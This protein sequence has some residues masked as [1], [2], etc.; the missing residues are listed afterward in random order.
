MSVSHHRKAEI[1]AKEKTTKGEMLMTEDKLIDRK[2]NRIVYLRNVIANQ[3]TQMD[4]YRGE[5]I[6]IQALL[7]EDLVLWEELSV[8]I[9]SLKLSELIPMNKID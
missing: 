6:K 8:T 7:G 3:I 1:K 4:I 5:E 2:M 9:T